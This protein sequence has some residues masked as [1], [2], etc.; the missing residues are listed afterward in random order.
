MN[1]GENLKNLRER[2]A[3]SI[4]TV[5]KILNISDSLYSR[6]EKEIQI[7]PLK[8]LITVCKYFN[9]SLNYIFGFTK[10]KEAFLDIDISL[11]KTRIK[12]FRKEFGLTQEKL[13]KIL[14]TT[15]TVICGYEKGRYLIATPFL[16]SICKKYNISA[17]YLLGRIDTNTLKKD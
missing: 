9:V 10:D 15:K 1:Y 17:D 5:A 11:S 3:L 13:A 2:Q 7:I 16:Y 4:T 14:N 12:E 6:Y 8:H